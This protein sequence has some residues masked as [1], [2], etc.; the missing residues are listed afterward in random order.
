MPLPAPNKITDLQKIGI[1]FMSR[2]D[3]TFSKRLYIAVTA[4]SAMYNHHWGVI[5]SMAKRFVVSRT[6]I[7]ILAETLTE[8]DSL[9]FGTTFQYTEPRLA[10]F[11]YMLSLRLEGRCSIEAISTI[12]KRFEI[13]LDSTG[14][15]SEYL[16][17]FGSLLPN[18]L[19]TDNNEIQLAV[20]DQRQLFIS[21]ND[22]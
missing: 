19:S 4:L 20:F 22:N 1:K 13:K 2:P 6:Y 12:M 5:T 15:I 3:L 8:T 17:Y 16:T 10:A 21:C 11:H 18:T 7:Y 14:S 9:L